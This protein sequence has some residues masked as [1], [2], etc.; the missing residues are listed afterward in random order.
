MQERLVLKEVQVP[1]RLVRSVVHRAATVRAA[2]GRTGKPGTTTE[3]QVQ[4][5]PGLLRVE[6]GA[7]HPPRLAQ[8]QRRREQPQLVHT[9]STSSTRLS[10]TVTQSTKR[11]SP[12]QPAT[13]DQTHLIQRGAPVQRGGPERGEPSRL[14][15]VE[16][17][18]SKTRRHSAMLAAVS[19][20]TSRFQ[21]QDQPL[22]GARPAAFR[23]KTR[24][25]PG[26]GR[27]P[28]R[29]SRRAAGRARGDR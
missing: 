22:S 13:P 6:L 12:R 26:S 8:P 20:R 29:A 1:P 25:S 24:P 4:I 19:S 21:E 27:A 17:D 18:V 9:D 5:Q 10:R 3:L 14:R 23:S 16:R 15:A 7:R 11:S 28:R 2:R